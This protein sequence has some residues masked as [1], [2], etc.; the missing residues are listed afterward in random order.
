M[1]MV[2]AD[3]ELIN[4][5]DLE[6]ERRGQLDRDEIKRMWVRM[7]ADSGSYMLAIN[8]NIQEI[9]QLRVMETKRLQLAN[10][11]VITCDVVGPVDLRF[12]NRECTCRA[13]V[14]P[15]DSEPLLGAI[16]MEEMDVIIHPQRQELIVHPDHPEYALLR[17]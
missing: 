1:G 10:G 17:L 6:M 4:S 8:E 7:L 14:L 5:I 11:K 15:G 2:Y 16:P 9:L 3:I 12:A 13:I